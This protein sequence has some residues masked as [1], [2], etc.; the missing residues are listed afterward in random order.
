VQHTIKTYGTGEG[1]YHIL[2]DK[3]SEKSESEQMVIAGNAKEN[4]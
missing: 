1:E 3:I 2:V 4:F